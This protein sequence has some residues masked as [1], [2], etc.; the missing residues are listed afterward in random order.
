MIWTAQTRYIKIYNMDIKYLI[1]TFA[2][3]GSGF[4]EGAVGLVIGSFF[5]LKIDLSF[6][7]L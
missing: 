1:V 6:L 3:A 5:S 7:I 2:G 4:G